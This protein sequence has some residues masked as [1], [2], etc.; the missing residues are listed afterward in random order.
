MSTKHIDVN[1]NDTPAT[2]ET[3]LLTPQNTYLPLKSIMKSP[4]TGKKSSTTSHKS[5]SW[6]DTATGASLIE[7]KTVPS[8]F[9]KIMSKED[10]F[11]LKTKK[12]DQDKA[13]LG[14]FFSAK[15][16]QVKSVILATLICICLVIMILLTL[17][18]LDRLNP[19]E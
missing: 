12:G 19:E 8:K 11:K 15:T 13:V 18:L 17:I 10:S 9:K 16:G 14:S 1:S 4:S 5:V 2:F 3:P 6:T 7:I